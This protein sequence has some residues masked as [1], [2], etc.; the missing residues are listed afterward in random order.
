[1]VLCAVGGVRLSL[2][3]SILI[4]RAAPFRNRE[5]MR[6]VAIYSAQRIISATYAV[7]EMRLHGLRP[8]LLVTLLPVTML[9][10]LSLAAVF[11][12]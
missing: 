8:F 12:G 2:V 5:N 6:R 3:S 4:E 1:V 10:M 9:F 11:L 7:M